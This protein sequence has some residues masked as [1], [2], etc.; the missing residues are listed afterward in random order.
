MKKFWKRHQR[1]QK[2]LEEVEAKRAV[3]GKKQEKIAEKTEMLRRSFAL[4]K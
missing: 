4:K 2:A 3:E 1:E